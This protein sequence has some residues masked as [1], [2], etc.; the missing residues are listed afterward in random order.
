MGFYEEIA[1]YYDYIFPIGND[2]IEFLAKE[3]GFT[4]KNVL[5]IA[6]GTG[7]Y[8]IGL[9]KLGHDV[10]AVDLDYQMVQVLN[11]KIIDT[12]LKINAMVGNML[13]LDQLLSNNYNLAFCI[14]N[15]IVHLDKEKAIGQFFEIA[16]SLLNDK[17]KLIIQII[18]YDRIIMYNV[19]SLPTIK[20]DEIKLNFERLYRYEKEDNVVYF[21][22]ILKVDNKQIE[23]EIPL[24]P[25]LSDDL[26]KLLKNAG[27]KDIQLYGDFKGS[28][29]DK[30]DSFTVVAVAM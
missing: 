27:F 9:S 19:K 14:G 17:G 16:K 2:Q 24:Y 22:T 6:C 30:S 10:T 5:D 8:S 7:G 4:S 20:N 26:C 21:K 3:A 1:K 25:L 12:D 28:P 13:E 23:N 11:E 15:S 29:Y 18:N